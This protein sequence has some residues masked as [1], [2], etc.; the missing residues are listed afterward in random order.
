[1]Q[2]VNSKS[3]WLTFDPNGRYLG[4]MSIRNRAD[5]DFDDE[6]QSHILLETDR[7]INAGMS[8]EEARKEAIRRFGNVTAVAERFYESRRVTWFE[9]AKQDLRY[10]ARL[11]YRSKGFAAVA[12]LSLAIGIGANISV[13][14]VIDVLLLKSLAVSKPHELVSFTRTG[15]E[16]D[17]SSIYFPP[18]YFLAFRERGRS[19]ESLFAYRSGA[20]TAFRYPGQ[21][22]DPS[23]ERLQVDRVTANYFSE[24][25]VTAVI[26]RTFTDSD[27]QPQSDFVAVLSYDFWAQRLNADP[28]VIGRQ[29][30]VFRD[31]PFT[32]IGVA[33]AGF[34]GV[35]VDGR[36]SV[37][38]PIENVKRLP[39][40]NEGE[41]SIMGRLRPGVRLEEAQAEAG[42]IYSGLLAEVSAA[43]TDWNASRRASFLAQKLTLE[44]GDT[45]QSDSLRA[46]Y[47]PPLKALMAS[48][49]VLL[50]IVSVNVG[51]LLL[52]RGA[53]RQRELQIRSMLGSGRFRLV[54]QLITEGLLLTAFAIVGSLAV[55]RLGVKLLV[56]YAP[57]TAAAA[58]DPGLNLRAL[59]FAIAISITSMCLFAVAP[60]FRSTD[61]TRLQPR[62]RLTKLLVCIQIALSMVLLSGAALLARTLINLRQLE[63]G[64]DKRNVTVLTINNGTIRPAVAKDLIPQLAAIPGVLSVARFGNI[65]LLNGNSVQS[66]CVVNGVTPAADGDVSCVLM[67]VGTRFFETTGIRLLQGREFND[68]DEQN[69]SRVGIINERMAK[70]FF[71]NGNPLGRRIQGLEVIGVVTDTV[72]RSL[73]EDRPR[74]LYTP[75]WLTVMVPDIRFVVRTEGGV[76]GLP[77]AFGAVVK[78][79]TSQL[80]VTRIQNLDEISEGTL[81][82]ERLLVQFSGFFSGLALVLCGIGIY[83]TMSYV[84]GSRTKEIGI[85]MALGSNVTGV[86]TMLMRET[87]YVVAPGII[88]GLLTTVTTTRLIASLLFGVE[89][90]DLVSLAV[91]SLLLAFLTAIAAYLPARRASRVDPMMA[92]REE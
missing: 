83:G 29:I 7:L 37:W 13:F 25:G 17:S 71:G 14:S 91:A 42:V 40:A 16:P 46:R 80:Q 22:L 10:A 15:L 87:T 79:A 48:V 61:L 78:Q 62:M 54:R 64:F 52:A 18:S 34:T 12:L 51:G 85:R 11:L 9:H 28:H 75:L 35:N 76:Q 58:L 44:P 50:L 43:R 84:V 68:L 23:T 6:V 1:M 4:R 92:L 41:V 24:L 57:V 45:G 31:V 60:A 53:M 77:D 82:R 89:P 36:T 30:I 2:W 32:V 5:E 38:W 19:Y 20:N 3:F 8:P 59:G 21:T 74:T 66:G 55:A 39:N 73:R 56:S 90:I 69:A 63:A 67:N 26:G 72:Y 70:H 33:R 65:G 49:A 88:L 86:I 47:A 27:V 81:L